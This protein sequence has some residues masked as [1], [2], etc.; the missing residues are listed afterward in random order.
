M[1]ASKI[2]RQKTE[3]HLPRVELD[4]DAMSRVRSLLG[5]EAAGKFV[6]LWRK[7]VRSGFIS[8]ASFNFI[9]DKMLAA[10]V[11]RGGLKPRHK[12]L[13][14]GCGIGRITLPLLGYLAPSGS[15]EGFDV[16]ASGINWLRR[17]VTPKFPQFRFRLAPRIYSGLYHP[18]GG[19]DASTYILPYGEGSFDFAIAISVFTHMTPPAVAQYLAEIART[20]KPGGRLLCTSYLL[21]DEALVRMRAGCAA[22]SFPNDYGTYRLQ[23]ASMPEFAI[24]FDEKYFLHG[25]AEAGL[26]LKGKIQRGSWCGRGSQTGQDLVVLEKRTRRNTS[27]KPSGGRAKAGA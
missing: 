8:G 22:I 9:G 27:A 14:V 11:E 6:P 7:W 21:D 25:A 19:R 15:Y 18:K 1:T 20:L 17:Y 23:N 13:D 2:H 4:V 26:H 24:A 16:T 3:S 10:S 12:V 5:D